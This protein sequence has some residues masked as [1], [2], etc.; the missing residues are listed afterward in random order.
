MANERNSLLDDKKMALYGTKKEGARGAPKLSFSVFK[1]NP[2]I[3]VFPNDPNDSESKPI[4]AAMDMINWGLFTQYLRYAGVVQE[5]FEVRL[6]N[7]RGPPNKL[8]TDS[9]TIIGRDSEGMVYI[10]IHKEGRPA[11]R[12]NVLPSSYMQLV[13]RDGNEVDKATVSQHMAVG[14]AN[15]LDHHISH[16]MQQSY[17]PP[18]QPGGGG[19]SRPS[20]GGSGGGDN[21]GDD[22]PM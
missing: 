3:I 10:G 1:G 7:F 12:F 9:L 2:A 11:K 22:L 19:G 15:Q 6:K 8:F 20:S 4:R 13:D 17:E 14:L 5:A 21:F 18:Q 16:F